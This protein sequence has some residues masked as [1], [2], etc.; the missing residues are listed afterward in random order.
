M[1]Q[2]FRT[3]LLLIKTFLKEK[4]LSWSALILERRFT[5]YTI[6]IA[7]KYFKTLLILWNFVSFNFVSKYFSPL[8]KYPFPKRSFINV[9]SFEPL[10]LPPP[11]R[12]QIWAEC[13]PLYTTNGPKQKTSISTVIKINKAVGLLETP[14]NTYVKGF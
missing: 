1:A 11:I 8:R 9:S 5:F 10:T 6:H 12:F 3:F 4:Y 7:W 13:Y 2:L 14:Y